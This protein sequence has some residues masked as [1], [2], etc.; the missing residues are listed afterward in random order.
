MSKDQ[1]LQYTV[2]LTY[3]PQSIKD[4]QDQLNKLTANV[5][6]RL[7]DEGVLK[8]LTELNERFTKQ[9]QS[10]GKLQ[11][12][13]SDYSK[14]LRESGDAG[15]KANEKYSKSLKD[16]QAQTDKASTKPQVEQLDMFIQAQKAADEQMKRHRINMAALDQARQRHTQAGGAMTDA[17]TKQSAELVSLNNQIQSYGKEIVKLQEI[18]QRDGALTVENEQRLHALS[19]AMKQTK[20]AYA[21][22]AKAIVQSYQTT[23]KDTQATA[24]QTEALQKSYQ[25]QL[26]VLALYKDQITSVSAQLKALDAVKKRDGTLSDEQRQQYEA[27][28]LQ[29]KTTKSEY[30]SLQREVQKAEKVRTSSGQEEKEAQAQKAKVLLKAIID[31]QNATAESTDK[32]SA[33]YQA[34]AEGLVRLQG[35]IDAYKQQLSLLQQVEKAGGTLTDEQKMQQEGLRTALSETQRAY[36]L[37]RQS[38]VNATQAGQENVNQAQQGSQTLLS[39]YQT[40]IQ[41]IA[42]YNEQI[43]ATK[44]AMQA[45]DD[46]RSASSEL[47]QDEKRQYASLS[48]Q[49]QDLTAQRNKEQSQIRQTEQAQRAMASTATSSND[50]IAE[51]YR[52]SSQALS[53]L[54]ERQR[55]LKDEIRSLEAVQKSSGG[56]TQEQSD[57]LAALQL[58]LKDV[59]SEIASQKRASVATEQAQRSLGTSYNDIQKQ[60]AA[61]S[62]RIREIDDPL[63]KNKATVNALTKQYNDLNNKL[64]TIDK[65]MG[66]SQ[67]NVGNYT[68][69]IR[70]AANSIAIFQGPLGPLAG[71]LNSVATTLN[72]VNELYANKRDKLQDVTVSSRLLT[73]RYGK[74]NAALLSNIPLIGRT[75]IGLQAQAVIAG[76]SSTAIRGLNLSLG[77]L[78]TAL[79]STGVGALVVALGGLINFFRKTESGAQALRVIMAGISAVVE[80]FRARSIALGQAIF[81]S[82]KNPKQAI[83]DL[84]RLIIENI[85]NRVTGAGRVLSAFGGVISKALKGDFEGAKQSAVELGDAFVQTTTGV[86]GTADGIKNLTKDIMDNI[87]VM[88]DEEKRLNA[89]KVAQR[90]MNVERAKSQRIVQEARALA[91][92]ATNAYEEQLEALERVKVIETERFAEEKAIA[93]ERLAISKDRLD[94]FP[95]DEAAMEEH[96]QAMIDFENLMREN[97]T[98]NIR[99]DRDIDSVKRRMRDREKRELAEIVAIRKKMD[100][101]NTNLALSELKRMNHFHA[102]LLEERRLLQDQATREQAIS[103]KKQQI[104]AQEGENYSEIKAQERAE[105]LINAEIEQK[106]TENSIK[107]DQLQ[108]DVQREMIDQRMAMRAMERDAELQGQLMF[109]NERNMVVES[110]EAKL[111]SIRN[112]YAQDEEQLIQRRYEQIYARTQDATFARAQAEREIELQKM[113]DIASAEEVIRQVKLQR[114][115]DTIDAI[116]KA[117]LAGAEL[118]FG[119]TKAVQSAATIVDTLKGAQRA[120]SENPPPSPIGIASAA[121]VVAKGAIALRKINATK[122]G[123]T[124]VGGLGGAP[125]IPKESFGLVEAN[126][127]T[128][129]TEIASQLAGQQ[130]QVTNT[131][132]LEGELDSEMLALKVRDGNNVISGQTVSVR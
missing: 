1:V 24:Q 107:L 11:T 85:V 16:V 73:G 97:A 54:L 121:A 20:S 21:E 25:S 46:K 48:V 50:A 76:T 65:E 5:K 59:N 86:K 12:S 111:Q 58:S 72:R 15:T 61:L 69:S 122:P 4:V 70:A 79:I 13:L 37:Q 83:K 84:G 27:L 10:L 44:S 45:L 105:A 64:K 2:Q 67:R 90:E 47:T 128:L 131:I 31:L 71:R 103:D 119:Q 35:K 26:Q 55:A 127:L 101:I 51:S 75:N 41:A 93:E 38:I 7:D 118:I 63:G 34:Q 104:M 82:L 8:Q 89:L 98:L 6:I 130:P 23:Q 77:L 74:L 113:Q 116:Q 100:N 102:A 68:D 95:S 96:A 120:L 112:R 42:K 57:R 117:S 125:N 115:R 109:Y 9:E 91:R 52:A 92:D 88:T 36:N 18:R 129:P 124:S 81:E 132:I 62:V 114:E 14:S 53:P 40:Q 28:S 87:K 29:L 39:S 80:T 33:K 99:I 106:L 22:K 3:D 110:A 17:Y 60:M 123:D 49:L 94:R 108:F 56:A 43:Q 66:N 19:I 32:L 78:K 126:K 30:A